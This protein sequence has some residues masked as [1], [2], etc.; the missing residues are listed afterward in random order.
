MKRLVLLG[1]VACGGAGSSVHG[2]PRVLVPSP[3]HVGGKSALVATARETPPPAGAAKDSPFPAIG[4]AALANGMGVAV[5]TSKAIP[6]VQVRIVVKAGSGYGAVPGVADVTASLLQSGGTRSLA[7]DELFRRIETLGTGLAIATE[8]DATVLSI[9]VRADHLAEALSLL[10]QVVREP[11]FDEGG[12]R[13][14]KA[15]MLDEITEALRSDG[16]YAA[17]RVI[18][19][20]LFPAKS[21]YHAWGMLPSELQRIDAGQVRDFY[22]RFWVP[23]NTEVVLAG[24]VGF[25]AGRALVEECFAKWTGGEAPQVD[26]AA[27]AAAAAKTRVIL[28]HRP[29]SLHSDVFLAMLAPPRTAASWPLVRVANQVFDGAKAERLFA[30][31]PANQSLACRMTARVLE[32]AHGPQALVVYA[33]SETAKTVDAVAGLLNSV[34]GM[35]SA[36]PTRSETAA[37]SRYLADSFAVRMETIGSIADLVVEQDTFGLPEGYWDA[38]RQELRVAD[39]EKADDAARKLYGA[40]GLLVVVAGDADVIAPALERARFG[41]VVVVDPENEF[42]PRRAP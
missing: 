39:A 7:S 21:P 28:A 23:K 29:K 41:D 8:R 33:S 10:A 25:D 16:R 5:I 26:F 14:V 31:V 19:H 4:R 27:T 11:R 3:E 24:D 38:Y 35:A 37:A 20:E 18:F 17:N 1:L 36:P 2:E 34:A 40:K 6:A 12:L 30:D 22:R 15:R 42:L 13:K 9:A 32:L